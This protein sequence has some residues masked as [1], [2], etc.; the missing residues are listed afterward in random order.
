MMLSSILVIQFDS[1]S[2][3][4]N[5]LF[6]HSTTIGV[7]VCFCRKDITSPSAK[8]HFQNVYA[9]DIW[10]W[11]FN[12]RSQSS[13][14]KYKENIK[15]MDNT[16]AEKILSINPVT[17]DFKEEYGG[18]T[19][20]KGVIAEDVEKIIPEAVSYKYDSTIDE[21]RV[22]VDQTKFIPYMIKMIQIQNDRIN[23]LEA[24]IKEL[25]K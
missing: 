9:R 23:E 7:N 24:K 8:D 14:R 6:R 12:D 11:L 17:F 13:S 10:A 15:D 21:E 1:N 19:D 18:E 2:N 16:T 4:A 25:T 22:L 3:E 5:F 20:R